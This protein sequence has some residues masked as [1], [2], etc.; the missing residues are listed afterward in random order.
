M[1]NKLLQNMKPCSSKTNLKKNLK[2]NQKNSN[3]V[4]DNKVIILIK[5]Y[6]KIKAMIKTYKK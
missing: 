4:K 2:L 6:K 3:H 1:L 5:N